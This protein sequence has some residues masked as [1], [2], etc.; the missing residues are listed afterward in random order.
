MRVYYGFEVRQRGWLLDERDRLRDLLVKLRAAARSDFENHDSTDDESAS[1]ADAIEG[2]LASI[3]EA[4]NRI[5]S[6]CYGLCQICGLAIPIGRL[7][8]LPATAVCRDCVGLQRVVG[9]A[10]GPVSS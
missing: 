2:R 3:D 5:T 4:L 8:S 9:S 6:D 10:V 1:Q 7:R